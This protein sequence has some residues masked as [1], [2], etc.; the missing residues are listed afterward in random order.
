M[1]TFQ[2]EPPAKIQTPSNSQPLCQQQTNK[3]YDSDM[4][5]RTLFFFVLLGGSLQCEKNALNSGY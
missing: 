5:V 2:E 4:C 3:H 1:S